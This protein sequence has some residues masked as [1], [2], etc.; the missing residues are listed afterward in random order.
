[1]QTALS[2]DHATELPCL[3]V[4]QHLI[5]ENLWGDW[6][7]RIEHRAPDTRSSYAWQAW[8]DAFF[9]VEDPAPVLDAIKACYSTHADHEVRLCAD[10]LQPASRL[11]Y[12][13]P[14]PDRDLPLVDQPLPEAAPQPGI[15]MGQNASTAVRKVF[16]AHRRWGSVALVGGLL[17][18]ALLF[19]FT[20]M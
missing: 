16:A 14:T 8:G 2:S 12:R 9:A 3:A 17:V 19:G 15:V 7:I 5:Q 20:P 13:I 11:I 1:M 10:K 18:S 4:I 6:V